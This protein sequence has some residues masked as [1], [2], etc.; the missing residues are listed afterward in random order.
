MACQSCEERRRIMNTWIDNVTD[1]IKHPFRPDMNVGG[2]F[3]FL[4]LVIAL[5]SLWGWFLSR[6]R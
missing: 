4:G 6:L 2:W 5:L 1:W 3:A